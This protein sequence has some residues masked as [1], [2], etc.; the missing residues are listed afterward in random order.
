[1]SPAFSFQVMS[2]GVIINFDPEVKFRQLIQD[3]KN[4]VNEAEDFFAGV[5]I[6]VNM[7]NR[8]FEISQLKYIINIIQKYNDVDNIYF[9]NKVK[10]QKKKTKVSTN[11]DTILL[12]RTLRSGQRIK[13]PTNIVILGDINPGAEVIAGGD[14]IVLGRLR[15]VVHAGANGTPESQVVALKLEPTQLR[16]ADIISRPPE[17]NK[18]IKGYKP[19]KAYIKDSHIIVENLTG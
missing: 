12:K 16:I 4:H 13:Y 5:D 8:E 14:V 18:K 2:K 3:L 1:M 6:Y 19:E 17:S 11:K 15:G 10:S 7:N 9:T